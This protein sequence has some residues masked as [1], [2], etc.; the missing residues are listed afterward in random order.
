MKSAFLFGPFI[1]NLTYELFSYAPHAIN[2]KKEN[3]DSN[4][5]VY[6]RPER[7]DLYGKYADILIP[8]RIKN[9]SDVLQHKYL[10]SGLSKSNYDKMIQLFKRK[11]R[12]HYD[13]K[14]HIYP[15]ITNYKSHNKWQFSRHM[16][17]YEFKPRSDNKKLI[18]KHIKLN[19]NRYIVVDL[20][21][22]Y[23]D[24]SFY[25]IEELDRILDK[26]IMFIC[27]NPNKLNT[28]LIFSS[29]NIL[30]LNI[31]KYDIK[32]SL[33]GCLILCIKKALFTISN[34]FSDATQ[35]SLLLGTKLVINRD[36]SDDFLKIINPL[37]T[38]VSRFIE[39]DTEKFEL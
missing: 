32:T 29:R 2:I 13:I 15:D 27:Y 12:D 18:N 24:E 11:Y 8:L 38:E 20:S 1:G 31:L 34:N 17:N 30:D 6:T 21:G 7:L 39:L 37:N 28:N 35:L 22:L 33:I 23:L 5:I 9:D 3:P 25:Y 19:K 16:L 26:D 14:D 10:L 36:Y 4:L